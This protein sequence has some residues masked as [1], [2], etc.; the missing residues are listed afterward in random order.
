MGPMIAVCRVDEVV[1]G[2]GHAV[3]VEGL[4]IAIFNDGGRFHVLIGRCPHAGGL[5][6]QGW[7]EEGEAVCPLH[8][9]QFKLETGRCT[10][11]RGATVHRFRSEVRDGQVWAEI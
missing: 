2:R 7:I 9:W 8:R 6:G 5:L 10:T 4:P 1:D 11:I 3:E